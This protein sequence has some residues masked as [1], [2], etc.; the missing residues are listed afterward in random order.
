MSSENVYWKHDVQRLETMKIILH[1]NAEFEAVDVVLQV[2]LADN[3]QNNLCIHIEYWLFF[4]Q[5]NHVFEVPDGYKM[6]IIPENSG[7]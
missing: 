6:C 7:L 2:Q 3:Q 1:G 4:M 5:G